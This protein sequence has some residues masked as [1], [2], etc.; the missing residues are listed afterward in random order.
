MRCTA[1]LRET[2]SRLGQ[3][4][5]VIA[6]LATVLSVPAQAAEKASEQVSP[7]MGS[8][9]QSLGIEVPPFRGLEPKLALGYS[10]EGRNGLVGVGW[11]L[12]GIST[13]ERANPG[14]GTPKFDSTDIYM[15]DGQ[16]L[17]ACQVGSVS[18][19]CTSGGT[20]STKTESYLK[21]KFT[22]AS[23]IWEIWG[24]DGTKTVF[25]AVYATTLGTWR[26]GQTSAVD[27]N[28]NTVTYAWTCL[29]GNYGDCYPDNV[30]YNGYKVTFNR[31]SRTDI[32][33]FAA[34]STV[35]QTRW[36]LK[37]IVV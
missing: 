3:F 4:G 30:Q 35:G 36:R 37:S 11:G 14:R 20:H 13:I 15:L 2:N 10:S 9:S 34:V 6:I 28:S 32:V 18:P 16:E 33:S 26:W 8:F 25:S 5:H 24:K 21:I 17:V 7:F 31:E 12:S 29:D 1:T 27:T 22:S 19:S 23:N